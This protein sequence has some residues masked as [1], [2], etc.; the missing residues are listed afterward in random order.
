M[1]SLYLLNFVCEEL[2]LLCNT[3][4]ICYTIQLQQ[5][6]KTLDVRWPSRL[7][8]GQHNFDKLKERAS[9]LLG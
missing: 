6:Q 4:L 9:V 3:M 5:N 8:K 2:I 1:E 7:F